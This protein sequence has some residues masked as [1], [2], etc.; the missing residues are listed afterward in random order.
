MSQPWSNRFFVPP[1]VFRGGA[2]L[3]FSPLNQA[4]QHLSSV[5]KGFRVGAHCFKAFSLP[6]P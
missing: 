1:W 4:R 6:Q 2:S 3:H 5:S